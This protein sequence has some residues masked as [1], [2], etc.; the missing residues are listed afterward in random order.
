L[1]VD[2]VRSIETSV[3]VLSHVGQNASIELIDAPSSLGETLL[4]LVEFV[5]ALQPDIRSIWDRLDSRSLNVGLQAASAP[6]A[7]AFALSAKVI[8]MIAA[9]QFE[10]VFTVYAPAKT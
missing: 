4:G 5:H 7:A 9:L 6:H 2:F 10:V 1:I 8:E 3:V